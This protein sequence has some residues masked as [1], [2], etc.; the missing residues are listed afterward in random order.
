MKIPTH[1]ARCGYPAR[2]A[3]VW[4]TPSHSV[5]GSPCL[6]YTIID[7]GSALL[8]RCRTICR[9]RGRKV[10]Q[11]LGT[12]L[13][14]RCCR[15]SSG[16][17]F[18]RVRPKTNRSDLLC[19]TGKT[20]CQVHRRIVLQAIVHRCEYLV[21]G[22]TSD[23][24]LALVLSYVVSTSSSSDYAGNAISAPM[25]RATIWKRYIGIVYRKNCDSLYLPMP[26]AIAGKPSIG[27]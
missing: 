22:R 9:H 4:P 24:L 16:R 23:V 11:H 3:C 8:H 18:L 21:I 13:S 5:R 26:N 27:I 2:A 10:D 25:T 20:I 7:A 14:E 19:L 6:Y 15:F 17:C 12:N 1:I